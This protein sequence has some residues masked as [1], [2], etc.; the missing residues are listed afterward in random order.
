MDKLIELLNEID[1]IESE[2]KLLTESNE[3]S[4]ISEL[5]L[6]LEELKDEHFRQK[7]LETGGF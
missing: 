7:M 6:Q 5:S 3:L 4:K 1:S 2:I